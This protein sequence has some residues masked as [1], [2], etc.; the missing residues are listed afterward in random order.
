MPAWRRLVEDGFTGAGGSLHATLVR[1]YGRRAAGVT[2]AAR[3]DPD[4]P[5]GEVWPEQ[6]L[7]LF[8]PLGPR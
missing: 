2:R 5:V 7:T 4:A 8:R 6:W 1:R 3:P